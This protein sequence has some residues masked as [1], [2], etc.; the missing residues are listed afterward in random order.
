MSGDDVKVPKVGKKTRRLI[1]AV[2]R[3]EAMHE[4]MIRHAAAAR[5]QEQAADDAVRE[6]RQE[7]RLHL[8]ELIDAGREGMTTIDADRAAAAVV[9]AVGSWRWSSPGEKKGGAS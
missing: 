7:L 8:S 9:S 4:I 3:A 5:V 1:D 6:A 2:A